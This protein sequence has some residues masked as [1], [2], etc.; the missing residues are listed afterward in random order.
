MVADNHGSN[1][2]RGVGFL[3]V[4]RLSES[5]RIMMVLLRLTLI[6]GGILN[7]VTI[8]TAVKIMRH[9]WPENVNEGSP[10]FVSD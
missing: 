10:W 4:L 5:A 8:L 1:S 2:D 7:F 9:Q 6:T 3:L